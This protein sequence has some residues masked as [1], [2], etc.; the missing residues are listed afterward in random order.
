[1]STVN[2]AEIVDPDKVLDGLEIGFHERS[3]HPDARVVDEDID[4]A[5]VG[6]HLFDHTSHLF[7]VAHVA[8]DHRRGRTQAA[9][10]L[11]GIFQAWNGAAAA[12]D[13]CAARR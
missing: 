6:N 12:S 11:E 9:H 4:F 5:K 1:M 7:G 13:N 2:S 3:A 10:F 8:A